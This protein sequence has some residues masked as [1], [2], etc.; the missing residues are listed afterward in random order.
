VWVEEGKTEMTPRPK[1]TKEERER[2]REQNER[3]RQRRRRRKQLKEFMERLD[4]L[5]QGNDAMKIE[6]RDDAS[7]APMGAWDL[8]REPNSDLLRRKY[9]AAKAIDEFEK[10]LLEQYNA[11]AGIMEVFEREDDDEC[12]KADAEWHAS[13]EGKARAARRDA[14]E[15]VRKEETDAMDRR[16]AVID[17]LLR[18]A[19]LD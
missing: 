5:F 2:W 9:A 7:K 12:D 10:L 6:L 18:G 13:P 8:I 1:P 14:A 3:E 11:L 19:K 15:A 17:A 4:R 16:Q